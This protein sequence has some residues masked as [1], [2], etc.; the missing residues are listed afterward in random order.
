MRLRRVETRAGASAS[1]ENSGVDAKDRFEMDQSLA[2][3]VS[4]SGIVSPE[5]GLETLPWDHC[6]LPE[7]AHP[8][9]E[10]DVEVYGHG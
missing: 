2:A 4:R 1:D 5:L 3:E 10:P 6:W 7:I 9:G 8:V